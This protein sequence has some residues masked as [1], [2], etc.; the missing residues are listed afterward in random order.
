MTSSFYPPYH[1]GG[2]CVHVKNLAEELARRGHEVHVIHSL[3][4]YRLLRGTRPHAGQMS[5]EGVHVHA[6]GAPFKILDPLLAYTCGTSPYFQ[7][8]FE[9]VVEDVRP[10]V[11]HHHN[12]DLLGYSVLRKLE[13]YL[14]LYT[15]HD[16]YLICP[17]NHLLRNQREVCHKK[18]CFSCAIMHKRPPQVW[19]KLAVSSLRSAIQSIDLII[20]PSDYM[21]KRLAEEIDLRIITIPNFVPYPPKDIPSMEFSNYF[22]FVGLLEPHKGI[23]NLLQVFKENRSQLNRKLVIVGEGSLKNHIQQFI[24][25]NSLQSIV[26]Y[27]G[28]VDELRLYSLY[29][30]ADALIIP[31]VWPENAPLTTLEALSVGTP[32][33]GTNLG[34]LPEIVG[35]I[36]TGLLFDDWN[37]LKNILMDFQEDQ[38]PT[39]RLIDIYERNFSPDTYLDA[40]LA[41]VRTD[42]S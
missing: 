7:R 34:G 5:E 3:D 14:C 27:E 19:R 31:S 11:V 42:H 40:Y 9:E 4:A 36:D 20:S 22:L 26:H 29:K 17:T 24:Q 30:N 6:S 37:C 13:R 35:K 28:W 2:A 23:M 1:V 18:T 15:S 25:N 8:Q 12:V 41:N 38:Y 21:R 32:V 16:Y 39:R 10:D 33:I